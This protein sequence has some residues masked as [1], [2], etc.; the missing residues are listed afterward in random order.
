MKYVAN[1]VGLLAVAMFVLSYQQKKRRNIV[2]CNAA[3]RALY[4]L[5]YILLGAFEGAV[6]DVVGIFASVAAQHKDSPFIKKYLKA[7]MVIVNLV[8]IASGLIMYKNVFS[9]LPMLGV[10]F[11][12]GAFWFT[13]EKRIR[14]VSFFGSP[15]WLAYNLLSGAYGSA[16][17]DVLSICSIGLAIYR[18]DIRKQEEKK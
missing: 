2:L 6:L 10:L 18:Y 11:H 3:S 17:G 15:F 4:V 13:K 14:I 1:A 9:L 12:T 8:I 5:Q 7:V 16:V